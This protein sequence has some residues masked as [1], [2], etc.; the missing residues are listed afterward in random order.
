VE[1]LSTACNC[2]IT[3]IQLSDDYTCVHVQKRH[4]HRR[5]AIVAHLSAIFKHN[6]KEQCGLTSIRSD[7][8]QVKIQLNSIIGKV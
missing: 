5:P 7:A 1:C 4:V 8:T 3:L 6:E 2:F